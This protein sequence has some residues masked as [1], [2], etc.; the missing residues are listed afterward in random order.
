[1]ETVTPRDLYKIG[2]YDVIVRNYLTC[3]EKGDLSWEQML[4]QIVVVL[5]DRCE[6]MTKEIE[7][8]QT[9]VF[10]PLKD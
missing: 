7:Q 4:M 9:R 5:Y 10:L 6:R 1:M 3:W 8:L 2:C